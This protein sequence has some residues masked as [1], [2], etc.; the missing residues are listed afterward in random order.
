MIRLKLL[1]KP[2]QLASTVLLSGALAV[3][4]TEYKVVDLGVNGRPTA[5][6]N[7]GDVVGWCGAGCTF[8]WENG[9]VT[10]LT[11]PGQA[12]AINSRGA[13]AGGNFLFDKGVLTYLGLGRSRGIAWALNERNQVVGMDSDGDMARDAFIWEK[14]VLRYLPKLP[15]PW[16]F[17]TANAINDAG[18]IVGSA[19]RWDSSEASHAVIWKQTGQGDFTITDLGP[20]LGREVT[21]AYAINNRGVVVGDYW[22]QRRDLLDGFIWDHGAVTVL[23]SRFSPRGINSRGEVV[24]FIG[25]YIAVW[26]PNPGGKTGR[27]IQFSE[28]GSGFGAPTAINEAGTVT[29]CCSG[30]R[31]CVAVRQ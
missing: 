25:P 21:A 13:I 11:L 14:G 3:A 17:H 10:Y 19:F 30:N 26:L 27:I 18:E 16:M 8:L 22:D 4:Q 7:R 15:S 24:G 23:P 20:L 12:M 6:N 9:N 31:A 2:V 1:A 5:I 28:L 29:G